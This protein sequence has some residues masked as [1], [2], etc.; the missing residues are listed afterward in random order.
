VAVSEPQILGVLIV[1]LFAVVGVVWSN[2]RG[3]LAELKARSVTLEADNRRLATEHARSE[4]RDKSFEKGIDRLTKAIDDFDAR[5]GAQIDRLSRA[6]E[7]AK[8]TI[9]PSERSYIGASLKREEE[10]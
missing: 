1:V 10:K 8:R 6:V 2:L 3:E 7:G 9:T 5:I 4:E